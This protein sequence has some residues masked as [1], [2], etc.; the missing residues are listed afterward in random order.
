MRDFTAPRNTPTTA[1]D[2]K[3]KFAAASLLAATVLFGTFCLSACANRGS[4][5]G[6]Q[7]RYFFH[8]TADLRLF[9]GAEGLPSKEEAVRAAEEA[10]ALLKDLEQSLS[11]TEEGSCVYAFNEAEAGETVELDRAAYEVFSL[12]QQLYEETGG[13]Y[14]PSVYHS[15]EAYGFYDFQAGG[16]AP[17]TLPTQAQLSA[18]LQLSDYFPLIALWEE[19]GRYFAKKPEGAAVEIEGVRYILKVDFGGIAKGYACDR[20]KELWGAFE[21]G[22]FSFSGSSM[23]VGKYKEDR[24][25]YELSVLAPRERGSYL[26]ANV[27]DTCLST[28]ADNGLYYEIGGTRYS[29][30]IDP[31]TMMPVNVED[32]KNVA[33][34]VTATVLG[35]SAARCD[36]LTTSLMAMGTERAKEFVK[37]IDETV[38]FVVLDEETLTVYTNAP[39]GSFSLAAGYGEAVSI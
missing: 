28:S 5:Q 9:S 4:W 11:V 1:S 34:I 22:Y 10:E 17:E 18:F 36:A 6:F 33:G 12:A 2:M 3:K 31:E 19:D 24:A 13:C 35:E 38:W 26:T 30:I 7:K 21:Y 25:Y 16:P 37:T 20:V 8:T 39:E 23:A 32:G 29:Q 15:V 14:D 27:Q